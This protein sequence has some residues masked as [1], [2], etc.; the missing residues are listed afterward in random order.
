MFEIII[1]AIRELQNEVQ[2]RGSCRH[3]TRRYSNHL[4]TRVRWSEM[5]ET[6][7]V[8]RATRAYFRRFGDNADIPSNSSGLRR[9]SEDLELL[10]RLIGKRIAAKEYIVLE[11]A[12]GILAVYRITGDRIRYVSAEELP[13]A[14][15]TM[16]FGATRLPA[17]AYVR[18]KA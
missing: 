9:V 12:N 15:G 11:N 2:L 18:K 16:G 13:V 8:K 10:A 6:E 4:R 5:H 1:T 17:R 14:L 7:L 3:R